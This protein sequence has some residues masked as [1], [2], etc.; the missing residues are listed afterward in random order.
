MECSPPEIRLPIL[1][2]LALV[3]S[4]IVLFK[5]GVEDDI[6]HGEDL[7]NLCSEILN[8]VSPVC[9]NGV[10]RDK[11]EAFAWGRL[12]GFQ[13]GIRKVILVV[14]EVVLAEEDAEDP[15]FDI[16]GDGIG[17]LRVVFNFNFNPTRL[18]LIMIIYLVTELID[19]E[20]E[21]GLGHCFVEM[22]LDRKS[23]V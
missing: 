1:A 14:S 16:G 11:R 5:V 20:T 9:L 4:G 10:F 6:L 2:F 8:L 18:Y 15:I 22:Q 23:V 21:F 3:Q 7:S 12:D 17:L 19:G 13:K